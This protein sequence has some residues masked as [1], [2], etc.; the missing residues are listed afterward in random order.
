M[1]QRRDQRRKPRPG[2]GRTWK[3]LLYPDKR[4]KRRD[5]FFWTHCLY[6]PRSTGSGARASSF[7]LHASAARF[8]SR[9]YESRQVT[10]ETFYRTHPRYSI[11]HVARH[12][13]WPAPR[14]DG[15]VLARASPLFL[16]FLR[17]STFLMTGSSYLP[18]T[19]IYCLALSSSRYA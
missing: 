13:M 12:A 18:S 1:G 7:F 16:L 10:A 2:A 19:I 8:G 4:K 9:V 3:L 11:L 6:S 17:P 15:V 14:R 5:Y